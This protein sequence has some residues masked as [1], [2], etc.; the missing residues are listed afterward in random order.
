MVEGN[1]E[2]RNKCRGCPDPVPLFSCELVDLSGISVLCLVPPHPVQNYPCLF[3]AT[4]PHIRQ[5]LSYDNK[6][7]LFPRVGQF[8]PEVNH[9]FDANLQTKEKD[10]SKARGVRIEKC[11]QG[12]RKK[13]QQ[14]W[15]SIWGGKKKEEESTEK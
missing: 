1:T 2:P 4:F 3:I 10:T 7:L 6:E 8:Y 9:L 14:T 13:N 11:K 12:K 5:T 15:G